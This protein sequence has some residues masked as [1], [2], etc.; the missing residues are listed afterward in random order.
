VDDEKEVDVDYPTLKSFTENRGYTAIQPT[1]G[2][3]GF[4]LFH[5]N[6]EGR[7]YKIKP[8]IFQSELAQC[9]K[10]FRTGSISL[11]MDESGWVYLTK[12]ETGHQLVLFDGEQT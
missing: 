12:G 1:E 9:A 2:L 7:I 8:G 3:E 5:Y 10:C 6:C 4:A 11:A